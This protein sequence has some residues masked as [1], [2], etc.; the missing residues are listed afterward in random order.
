MKMGFFY[1]LYFEGQFKRQQNH[2]LVDNEILVFLFFFWQQNSFNKMTG[3]PTWQIMQVVKQSQR[4]RVEPQR[5]WMVISACSPELYYIYIK[6]L[7]KLI[8]DVPFVRA[9]SG[10]ESR[11]NFPETG[12]HLSVASSLQLL[13]NGPQQRSPLDLLNDQKCCHFTLRDLQKDD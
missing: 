5:W 13:P 10:N 4:W 6:A 2:Y 12:R 7:R 9:H 11:E 8:V 3:I 1:K